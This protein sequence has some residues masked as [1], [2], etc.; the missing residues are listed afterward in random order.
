MQHKMKMLLFE[1]IYISFSPFGHKQ[2]SK[3]DSFRSKVDLL[4]LPLALSS[5]SIGNCKGQLGVIWEK[6]SGPGTGVA[7]KLRPPPAS[8]MDNESTYS[9]YSYKSSQSRS[10][11]KYRERRDR[12]RS[13]N[14]DGLIHGDKSLAVQAAGESLLDEESTVAEDRDDNWA[15]TTTVVTGTSVDSISN[16]DLTRLSKDSED[17]LPLDCR[18]YVS[19]MVGVVLGLFSLITPL[20]FLGLPQLLWR[21]SL[22]PCGTPCEGLYIS[23]AFKLLILLFSTWALFLRPSRAALP[24]FF[25]FRCLLLALVFLF[26]GSYWLFYGVRVLEPK[27]TDYRGIVGYAASLV[28]ALLFI[29]YLALVLLEVRHLQPA[30]CLK[31]VRTTDGVS[32]FYNVGHLSIQRAAVWVLDQYYSDFPVHN[33]A[34]LNLPKSILSKKTSAFKVYNLEEDNSTNN[35]SGQSRAMMATAGRRRDNSHTE[36]YYEEAEM[37]RRIRKRKARLVVAVEEAFT[38]IK[39]YQDKETITSSPKHPREVMDPREAAQAIFAPMARAMQKY[40]RATRQQPYHSMERIINHLQFCVTHN[41]TPRAFLERYLAP[42]P[43][44]Q[45]LDNNRR[46]Q[47]TLLSEEPVTSSLHKAKSSA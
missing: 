28:D 44:L 10:S 46:R 43:T 4:R 13:K 35:S 22:D 37:E 34:L 16:E 5:K 26:V 3:I 11:R 24:R 18:R 6:G 31:V 33:P 32:R 25:V 1:Y 36:Y 12:H 7:L 21:D 29:Q 17:S 23:L 14:R 38:H 27:E 19:S 8:D 20:A 42:G 47:W 9:G 2:A 39:R 40:L 45:Y 15:E 30:F 41:M